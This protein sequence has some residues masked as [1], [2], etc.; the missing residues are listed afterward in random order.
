MSAIL[1]VSTIGR[2]SSAE[3][4]AATRPGVDGSQRG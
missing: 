2:L 4:N 3:R 1:A